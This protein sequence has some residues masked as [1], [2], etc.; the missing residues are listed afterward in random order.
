MFNEIG[1][2]KSYVY[3][4]HGELFSLR[5]ANKLCIKHAY[6]TPGFTFFSWIY[7]VQYNGFLTFY[8]KLQNM[9]FGSIYQKCL[10]QHTTLRRDL[11]ILFYSYNVIQFMPKCKYY[12]QRM[13]VYLLTPSQYLS[14]IISFKWSV[15][16]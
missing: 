9:N 10:I 3:N 5:L 11:T 8:D 2:L 16:A 4:M 12:L 1:H 7:D 6:L 15:G 14:S 13:Q